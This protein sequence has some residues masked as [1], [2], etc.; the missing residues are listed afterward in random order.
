MG[1]I[2]WEFCYTAPVQFAGSI[3]SWL[4]LQRP[5]R[6]INEFG[7]AGFLA[8]FLSEAELFPNCWNRRREPVG[9]TLRTDFQHVCENQSKTRA[10]GLFLP[11]GWYHPLT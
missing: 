9:L 7:A 3:P 6:I 8:M 2:D 11:H 4:P 5:H 10:P 1:V